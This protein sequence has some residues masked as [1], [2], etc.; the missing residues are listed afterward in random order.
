MRQSHLFTKV[1]KTF[2][3]GEEST[4]AKLLLR[5]GFIHKEMAGVFSFLPLGLRVL[6][7]I[8]AIIR[9]EMNVLGGQE[10]FLSSL[11]D[12]VLW[13]KSGRWDEKVV[14]IWFKTKLANKTEIGLGHTHEEPLTQLMRDYIGSYR[15]LPKYLYQFQTKFRNELRAKGG[16]LRTREFIMKDLYSFNRNEEEF[17]EFYEKCAGAYLQISNKVG[18]GSRTFRTFASGGSFSKFSDEFQTICEAGEDIIF[19]DQEKKIAVN[20]EVCTPEILRELG[21]RKEDLEEKRAI[22]IGNIFNLGTKY[23]KALGLTFKDERGVVKPVFMGSYGIGPARIMGVIVETLSDKNG[24]VWPESVAPFSC[25]VVVLKGGEK[26][27]ET[28]YETFQKQGIEVLYDDR[29]DATAG[30]KLFDA[31]L[32]GIPL[33]IVVSHKTVERKSVEVKKRN[34]KKVNFVKIKEMPKFLE[35]WI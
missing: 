25:H 32:V 31:D 6:N 14:D 20:K 2:P 18:L 3:K 11:Q 35:S 24:I 10:V 15:D 7:K 30:E 13:K 9:G 8:I 33:R 17:R 4:N 19:V 21:L 5:A 16:L 29:K 23:S 34:E 22:E 1:H 27:A 12:P 26:E 28:L